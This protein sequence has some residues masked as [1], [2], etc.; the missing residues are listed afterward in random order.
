MYVFTIQTVY[1]I[2][3][4]PNQY[5]SKRSHNGHLD[6]KSSQAHLIA[7]RRKERPSKEVAENRKPWQVVGRRV[8]NRLKA[9]YFAP[10]VDENATTL[11]CSGYNCD[12]QN[13]ENGIRELLPPMTSDNGQP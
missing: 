3:Y 13:P 6:R 2:L 12:N 9:L 5:P 7:R 8:G 11:A 4:K 1:H 10:I